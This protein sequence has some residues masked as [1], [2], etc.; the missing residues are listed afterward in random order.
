[1]K[2]KSLLFLLLACTLL[3]PEYSQASIYGD[4]DYLWFSLSPARHS[5]K[6]HQG[7]GKKKG[8]GRHS[9]HESE[10][11]PKPIRTYWLNSCEIASTAKAYTMLPEG[12]SKIIPIR[13][14]DHTV[15]VTIKTPLVTVRLMGP[16]TCILSIRLLIKR[17]WYYVRQNG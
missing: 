12:E 16:T 2:V 7:K 17:Y 15:S 4:N 6:E 8:H 11:R 14:K 10:H 1:M 9:G 13:R 5:G 3:I